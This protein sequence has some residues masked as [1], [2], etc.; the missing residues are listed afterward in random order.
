ME[1]ELFEFSLTMHKISSKKSCLHISDD[2]RVAADKNG[3]VLK[4]QQ[5]SELE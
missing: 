4:Q 1:D 2:K 3:L 5:E